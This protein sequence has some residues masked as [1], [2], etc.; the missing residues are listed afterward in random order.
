MIKQ[1][2]DFDFYDS[3]SEQSGSIKLPLVAGRKILNELLEAAKQSPVE[4]EDIKCT[5]IQVPSNEDAKKVLKERV[6]PSDI[7]KNN[8]K[9]FSLGGFVSQGGFVPQPESGGVPVALVRYSDDTIFGNLSEAEKEAVFRAPSV[10]EV[11]SKA[12]EQEAKNQAKLLDDEVMAFLRNPHSKDHWMVSTDALQKIA[13][14]KDRDFEREYFD[15]YGFYF[16]QDQGKESNKVTGCISSWNLLDQMNQLGGCIGSA[17]INGVPLDQVL[18]KAKQE[19]AKVDFSKVKNKRESRPVIIMFN[20]PPQS[21][22]DSCA[23]IIVDTI[24]NVT[25]VNFK[26]SLYKLTAEILKLDL[27]FWTTVCQNN[28][29]KDKPMMDV[30]IGGFT[31]ANMTPRDILILVAEKVIKPQHGKNKFALDALDSIKQ[32]MDSDPEKNIFV[33]PDCGFDYEATTIQAGFPYGAVKVVR[34]EREGHTFEKD[35]RNWVPCNH[36]LVNSSDLEHLQK[37]AL[38]LAVMVIEDHNREGSV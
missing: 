30:T 3:K 19:K 9:G 32:I 12:M 6:R 16:G 14:M 36:V 4:V 1:T 24:P 8:L 35:S 22:K 29:M 2:V 38:E 26:D 13:N 11:I 17:Q 7:F 23:D 31:H 28:Q 20:A 10:D 34:I 18:N 37:E 25:K 15:K 27:N 33:M 5:F 21:G